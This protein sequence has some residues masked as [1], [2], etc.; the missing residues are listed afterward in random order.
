M[1]NII[2]APPPPSIP[3][4]HAIGVSAPCPHGVFPISLLVAVALRPHDMILLSIAA[5]VGL[6]D[7]QRME[8]PNAGA[9]FAIRLEGVKGIPEPRF[10]G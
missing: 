8:Q 9:V 4:P 6:N 7:Q 5:S 10:R 2:P 1:A 3:F